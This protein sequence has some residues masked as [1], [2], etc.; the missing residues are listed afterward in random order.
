M[1]FN[2]RSHERSDSLISK[3]IQRII[4]SI[5]APTRG[6]TVQ[7]HSYLQYQIF[8]S[9]LPR[10]ERHNLSLPVFF[11]SEIS[12]HAPTRGATPFLLV[13]LTTGIF[14]STL[15]REERHV[16][17]VSPCS[18]YV[19][20]STLPREER[21]SSLPTHHQTSDFNPRSHERSDVCTVPFCLC[22][23]NFNPRSHERSDPLAVIFHCIW[24]ISIHAP[25]RGATQYYDYLCQ[26]N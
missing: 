21:H 17:A 23:V 6:A 18:C 2:P 1:D 26:D 14:Q 20:Q 7:P 25:T 12:I 10:E 15:P 11:D 22:P 19:F 5:H 13:A 9:T 16:G 3:A 24:L 4:I 8:Q